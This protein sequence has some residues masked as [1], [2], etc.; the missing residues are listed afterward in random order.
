MI[1]NTPAR[2]ARW[3]GMT[4]DEMRL[5]Q[6]VAAGMAGNVET[7]ERLRREDVAAGRLPD[8]V[9]VLKERMADLH[10]QVQIGEAFVEATRRDLA[11]AHLDALRHGRNVDRLLG[12]G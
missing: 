3:A 8:V 10:W 12:E 7:L 4:I 11:G 6:L 5:Q 1:I 2:L 9:A